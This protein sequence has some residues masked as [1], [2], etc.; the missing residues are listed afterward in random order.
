[1]D[2]LQQNKHYWDSRA[3][4]YRL[5]NKRQLQDAHAVDWK[6]ALADPIK[7]HFNVDTLQGL[8][9]LDAGCGPGIF[10]I[11]LAL[12][13]A[14]VTAFDYSP[15]ML[16]QSALLSKEYQV[17]LNLVQ[18][19][20]QDL[21]FQ[22]GYFDVVV[23]RNV[24]WNLNNPRQAYKEWK[25]VIKPKGMIVN[26]DANWYRHLV[27]EKAHN[28]YLADRSNIEHEYLKD[29]CEIDGFKKME[30]IARILPLTNQERPQWDIDIL[31]SLNMQVCADTH[32]SSRVWNRE[33]KLNFASTPLFRI[34]AKNT[35]K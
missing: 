19:D 5:I 24:T 2:I 26:F 32:I 21:P 23:S 30:E 20:T 34:V 28:A 18:G 27:D 25:R 22:D 7:E 16:A 17:E 14:R 8:T 35:L 6:C 9:I 29:Q 11:I 1:M 3:Q 31:N 10:S 13:K 15:E 12:E 33:E 4:G